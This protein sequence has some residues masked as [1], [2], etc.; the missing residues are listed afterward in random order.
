M[1]SIDVQSV[2]CFL[3]GFFCKKQKPVSGVEPQKTAGFAYSYKKKKFAWHMCEV[4]TAIFM[5]SLIACIDK[6]NGDQVIT[7]QGGHAASDDASG[8]LLEVTTNQ[9]FVECRLGRPLDGIS[10]RRDLFLGGTTTIKCIGLLNTPN[11]HD[12]Q[13]STSCREV[14]WSL[15]CLYV[16]IIDHFARMC[17]TAVWLDHASAQHLLLN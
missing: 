15:M 1:C 6:S 11:Y 13:N 17:Y 4:V 7:F 10:L 8:C 2:C 12:Y 16:S 14:K 3:E 9:S 5:S